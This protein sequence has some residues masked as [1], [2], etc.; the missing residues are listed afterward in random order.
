MSTTDA[1]RI[2]LLS[3]THFMAADGGDVPQPLL[4][5]LVGIDLIIHLGHISSSGALDRLETVAPTLAVQTELDDKLMGEGLAGEL[6]RGRTRGYTRVLEAGAVRNGIAEWALG[7]QISLSKMAG[8][9]VDRFGL[10]WDG[11]RAVVVAPRIGAKKRVDL[12]MFRERDGTTT[13]VALGA[14][15]I[16]GELGQG[17]TIDLDLS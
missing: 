14:I 12:L 9:S 10:G 17:P 8:V 15:L 11:D 7:R 3:D 5:A 6:D 13:T 16:L 4:D 2:A 1:R